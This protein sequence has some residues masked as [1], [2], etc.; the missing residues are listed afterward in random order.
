MVFTHCEHPVSNFGILHLTLALSSDNWEDN[1]DFG[2]KTKFGWLD[3]KFLKYPNGRLAIQLIQG[4]F[5]WARLTTN[6]PDV[7]LEPRE[8]HFNK[9]DC[10]EIYKDLIDCGH[11]E[12]TG[13]KNESGFNTYP[14]MRVKNHIPLEVI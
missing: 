10:W 14:V 6:L 11:F 12:D 2:F 7:D 13:K 4:G 1:M 9:S 8:F 5:P 3:A